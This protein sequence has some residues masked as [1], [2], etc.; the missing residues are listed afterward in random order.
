[1]YFS[2]NRLVTDIFLILKTIREIKI[3]FDKLLQ[4]VLRN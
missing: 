1:M 3:N 4:L 2:N